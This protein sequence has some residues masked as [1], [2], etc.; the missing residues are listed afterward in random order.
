ML[1]SGQMAL[2]HVASGALA[3]FINNRTNIWDVAAG[4]VL[5]RAVGGSVT[6]FNGRAIDYR[7]S[8][9]ISVIASASQDT[10]KSMLSLIQERYVWDY[11]APGDA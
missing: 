1:N 2:A 9:Y 7:R 8:N 11:A 4:E 6:D 3:G 10:Y 5:I